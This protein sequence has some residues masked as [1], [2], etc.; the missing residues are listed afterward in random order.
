MVTK[1]RDVKRRGKR[2]RVG[3]PDPSLTPVAGTVALAHPV[4]LLQ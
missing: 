1:V 4:I 3:V 2:V